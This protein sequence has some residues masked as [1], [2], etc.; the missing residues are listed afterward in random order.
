MGNIEKMCAAPLP[1]M[2]VTAMPL[3]LSDVDEQEGLVAGVKKVL[4]REAVRNLACLEA[5][6]LFVH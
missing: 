5:H 4:P 3:E 1:S 6:R 2:M